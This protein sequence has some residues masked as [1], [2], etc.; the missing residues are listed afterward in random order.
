[1]KPK[2]AVTA[3]SARAAHQT[4]QLAFLALAGALCF[5]LGTFSAQAE[6]T[7]LTEGAR[8]VG[9]TTGTAI[10]EVG[11]GAKKVGI[12]IGQGAAAAGKEIG[13]VAKEGALAIGHGAAEAG[14]AVGH[15][16]AE[17]GR[18]LGRAVRGE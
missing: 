13:R 18:E 2:L 8:E 7:G 3:L 5:V 17:G 16:A 1:M 9:R 14:K 15:A 6:E 10:R 4:Y 12:E 11:Q